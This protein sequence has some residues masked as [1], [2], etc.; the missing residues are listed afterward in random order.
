MI[1]Q[2]CGED[3]ENFV[4]SFIVSLVVCR[5]KFEAKN[6]CGLLLKTGQT[7]V[8][9][10][11]WRWDQQLIGRPG[12]HCAVAPWILCSYNEYSKN[13]NTNLAFSSKNCFNLLSVI[14]F[15]FRPLDLQLGPLPTELSFL[16]SWS[17]FKSLSLSLSW[18][19]IPYK[20]FSS[21]TLSSIA[22][23]SN[24]VFILMFI[25]RILIIFIFGIK[26]WRYEGPRF[27]FRSTTHK[28]CLFPLI[29]V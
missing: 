24:F 26:G 22:R 23:R 4:P 2:D 25:N 14:N 11:S 13:I 3:D 19:A 10:T 21:V 7:I 17:G 18:K 28:L 16:N 20:A 27:E 29:K 8:L 6:G 5:L 9:R 12:H 1:G 15:R